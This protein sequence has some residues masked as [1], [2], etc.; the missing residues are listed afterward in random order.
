M[1]AAAPTRRGTTNR[2]V[3]GNVYDRAARRAF[4]LATFGNGEKAPCYRCGAT[5]DDSTITTDRII[6][7]RDGGTYR[8][9]N[10]RPACG[11]CNSE[12]GGALAHPGARRTVIGADP[13]LT[14]GLARID[15]D[16]WREPA[17]DQVTPCDVLPAVEA[18]IGAQDPTEV[19]LAV[20]QFV[21]GPRASRSSTPQ[22]GRVARELINALQF[23]FLDRGVRVVLRSASQVKPWATDVRLRAAGL[24]L[25]G[26]PHA[27]DAGR[28]ALF[29]AVSDCGLPDPLSN[30]YRPLAPPTGA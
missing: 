18:L 8:R 10:I 29:A 7:G 16:D 21:V 22:G 9:D 11:P 1:T 19:L 15:L 5:L 26:K 6:P 25:P 12:T 23:E 28:H 17:L 2:N 3:R 13:G 20:E 4:L 14:T 24:Y 30:R 27:R